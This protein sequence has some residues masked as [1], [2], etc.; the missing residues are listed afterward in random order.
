MPPTRRGTRADTTNDSPVE[1]VEGDLGGR[2]VHVPK[3]GLYDRYRMDADLDEVARDPRV[4]SVDFFRK[5]PKAKV[6]SQIGPTLTPNFY[7]AM[8]AS[9]RDDRGAERPAH[10]GPVLRPGQGVEESV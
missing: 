3:G 8:S 7:Y 1:T 4:K 5:L 2:T 6:E 9:G 10:A